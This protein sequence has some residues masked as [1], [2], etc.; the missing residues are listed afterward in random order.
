MDTP[1]I[2]YMTFY[3]I[4]TGFGPEKSQNLK[5]DYSDFC[6]CFDVWYAQCTVYSE[7]CL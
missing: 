7:Y 1:L 6:K 2:L 4:Q 5:Y 3:K